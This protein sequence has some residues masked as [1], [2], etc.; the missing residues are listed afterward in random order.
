MSEQRERDAYEY[1]KI[2]LESAPISGTA[3]EV[4]VVI[5]SGLILL[6]DCR[7][8]IL[9]TL[10]IASAMRDILDV[11]VRKAREIHGLGLEVSDG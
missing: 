7:D 8:D 5:H 4:H 11:W 9:Q 10:G 6:D 3:N 1:L 2:D